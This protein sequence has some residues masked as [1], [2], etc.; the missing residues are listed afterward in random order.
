MTEDIIIKML[1]DIKS[2]VQLIAAR[3]KISDLAHLP[4]IIDVV[5]AKVE[6]RVDLMAPKKDKIVLLKGTR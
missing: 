6:R 3:E 2:S 1:R 5:I 4:N